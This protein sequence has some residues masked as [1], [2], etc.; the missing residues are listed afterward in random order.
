MHPELVNTS[1]YALATPV[2]AD[3]AGQPVLAVVAKASFDLAPGREPVL[4]ESQAP[5]ELAGTWW[6]EPGVSSPRYEPE[7]AFVK[8]GVDLVLIGHAQSSQGP[9]TQLDLG[10]RVGP[11]QKIVR[12]HGDRLWVPTALGLSVEGP[13]P[14][15][16]LPL[17]YELAFGGRDEAAG[18][19]AFEARNPVGRG[20]LAPGSALREPLRMPNFEDPNQLLGTPGEFPAPAGFGYLAP[21]WQGRSQYAGTYDATWEAERQPLLPLDFDRR[22]FNAGSP[23]LVVPELRGN[24]PV[25]VVHAGPVQR[26]AFNL[27]GRPPPAMRVHWRRGGQAELAARLDTVIVDTD[28]MRLFLLWRAHVPLPPRGLH[29]VSAIRVEA[30]R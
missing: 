7:I 26:L 25:L 29:A 2:L 17:C 22:F 15:E 5:V 28:A 30:G 13:R 8:S 1:P 27:P 16:R 12:A 23:G 21:H 24:E 20:Y 19:T 3:E 9:V 18:P 6:G 14:F 11:A 4:A 10:F